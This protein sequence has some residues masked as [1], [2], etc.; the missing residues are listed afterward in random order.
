MSLSI[1][2]MYPSYKIHK[3]KMSYVQPYIICLVCYLSCFWEG[4]QVIHIFSRLIY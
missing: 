2:N 1:Y 3:R 4:I